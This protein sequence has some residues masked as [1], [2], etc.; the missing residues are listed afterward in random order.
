MLGG[1]PKLALVEME[2]CD[3]CCGG[4]GAFSFTQQKLSRGI[5]GLK[6]DNIV[7]TTADV[8]VSGCHGCNLQ[9]SEGIARAQAP[10]RTLHTVQVLEMAHRRPKK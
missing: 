5:L 4:A 6:T 3:I 9:I 8:V 7:A 10:I 2:G 1:V